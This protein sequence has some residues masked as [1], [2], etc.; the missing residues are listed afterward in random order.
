MSSYAAIGTAEG[1]EFNKFGGY[2]GDATKPQ[3]YHEYSYTNREDAD[4]AELRAL[5]LTQYEGEGDGD[6]SAYYHYLRRMP[7]HELLFNYDTYEQWLAA[8]EAGT[9]RLG[10]DYENPYED[11][12]SE[13]FTVWGSEDR[14]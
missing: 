7:G 11:L 9:A 8:S 6:G 3:V 4:I 10:Y 5:I 1:W 12:G 14:G 13:Q 2:H